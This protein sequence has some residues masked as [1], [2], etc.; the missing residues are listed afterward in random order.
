MR[1]CNAT[2][3]RADRANSDFDQR[4]NFVYYSIW[5]V[6]AVARQ[7]RLAP[8]FRDWTIA[9][10]GAFRSGFPYTVFGIFGRGSLTNPLLAFPSPTLAI[11]GGVQTLNRAGFA[12]AFSQTIGNTGRNAFTGPGFYNLDVSLARSFALPWIGE[13]GRLTLRADAFNFLNHTN[14]G[15]PGPQLALA[16]FGASL[17]GRSGLQSGFP[18]LTPLNESS[19][20]MNDVLAAMKGVSLAGLTP[21]SQPKTCGGALGGCS[22]GARCTPAS[23]LSQP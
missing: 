14:L 20:I 19:R 15:N 5:H 10:L 8:V 21:C 16:T 22:N 1:H 4:Q 7:S 9:G 23:V 11:A 18:S 2:L 12:S 13:T 6:P 3:S 17:F